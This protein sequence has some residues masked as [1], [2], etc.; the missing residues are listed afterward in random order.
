VNTPPIVSPE[1]WQTAWEDLLV[2]EKALT[3]ARDALNTKRRE[4]PMVR[5]D[6]DYTF[7]GPEGTVGLTDLFAG[8]RQLIVQ[9]FMFD[10]SWDEGCPHCSF[11]ADRL[12]DEGYAQF[13]PLFAAAG[14]PPWWAVTFTLTDLGAMD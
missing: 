11:W 10:P 12:E 3:R 7:T 13:L 9:H 14:S 4:L 8:R 2:K 6:K 5:I 1:E